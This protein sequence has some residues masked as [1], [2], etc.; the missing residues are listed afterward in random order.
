MAMDKSRSAKKS[1]KKKLA[2]KP[3]GNKSATAGNRK[4]KIRTSA[5]QPA[6]SKPERK[7]GSPYIVGIGSSAG[8]LTALEKFFLKMPPDT[9]AAFVLVPHLSPTAK[10]LMVESIRRFT[11]MPV[12]MV[13]NRKKVEKDSV[14][15]IPPGKELSILDG[16]LVLSDID[17]SIGVRHPIDSFLRS[18]AKDQK[19]KA[20][21]I[22]LS[23][24]GTDGTLGIKDISGEGGVAIAQNSE[25]AEYDSMP[26]SANATGLVD[27]V[28]PPEKMPEAITN[29][30]RLGSI[31]PVEGGAEDLNN[32]MRDIFTLLRNRTG[33]DFSHNKLNTIQRR[34]EK[35]I[36]I[37][38]LESIGGYVKYLKRN[39]AELD[40]LF[41]ELLIGVTSFFR[42]KEAFEILRTKVIPELLMH[43]DPNQPLRVWVPGCSTGEEAYSVA[44]VIR[45]YMDENR[46]AGDVQVFASDIDVAAINKAR[47]AVYAQNV[48]A[49]IPGKYLAR[50]MAKTGNSYI[51]S[52]Q[53]R[54]MVIFA[55]HSLIKDPPF[56]RLD[57]VCCRNL[58]IYLGPEL[59]KKVMHLFHYVLKP[60][61]ILFLG[62]SESVGKQEDMFSPYGKKGN[63]FRHKG[64]VT[65]S[66]ASLTFSR[67]MELEVFGAAGGREPLVFKSSGLEDFTKNM[68][69]GDF[70]PP[71]AIIDEYGTILY[72]HGK[73]GKYLEPAA[74]D[75][76]LNIKSMA[77]GGINLEVTAGIRRALTKKAPVTYKNLKIKTGKTT[78]LVDLFIKPVTRPG[79]PDGLLMVVFMD[80]PEPAG[81]LK[82]EKNKAANLERAEDLYSE[83]KATKE[84]LKLTMEEHDN[85][86]QKLKTINEE[87]QS[88][89]EELQSTN[90]ELETSREELQS[91]NEELVTVNAEL[92]S[93]IEELTDTSNDLNNLL[94]STEIGTIFLDSDLRIKWFSP[95]VR[96]ILNVIDSDVGRPLEQLS[97]NLLGDSLIKDAR[98]VLQTLA[99]KEFEVELAN[100]N[101]YSMRILPYRTLDNV[102]DGVVIT[103]TDITKQ[104]NALAVAQ[105][106]R[107]FAKSIVSTVRE[108][109][110]VLDSDLRVTWVS[111]AFRAMFNMREGEA[112]DKS[113]HDLGGGRWDIPE[114]MVALR[115][116]LP[117]KNEIND[118][119]LSG[120]SERFGGKMLAVDA[121]EIRRDGS[122]ARM[123]LLVVKELPGKAR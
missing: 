1:A 80:V 22:I 46:M 44:M 13:E 64:K 70:A 62:S 12:Y 32:H 68:L 47:S 79:I 73:T 31:I 30:M 7:P 10:S 93:K 107:F 45:D 69:L 19:E 118:F 52:K 111:E 60:D 5:A 116:I 59:Q 34:I 21:G 74:G 2:L 86:N 36:S 89:N 26:A 114:L 3:A 108:P 120:Y 81:K 119:S 33:H 39:P 91:V 104:K 88:A 115:D 72:I 75:A 103:F 38:P 54:S 8:G 53:I 56:S 42:D 51:V 123:V 87:L 99:Q 43:N 90:E 24:T 92:Q 23:G 55:V 49:D 57:M 29:Y 48:E 102:I 20:I 28:L 101:W 25:T 14:Y 40:M 95:P 113:L 66:Q 63:F 94:V 65:M 122:K 41:K 117:G 83:L 9:G 96:S 15:I 82:K 121:R 106:E 78:H 97:S 112:H 17:A 11:H 50:Y 77:R 85:S 58:L 18:L 27:I 67:Q 110:L 37:L 100:H 84:T 76:T 61:G 35:R 105:E 6:V 98:K 16:T 4:K 71:A 109:I